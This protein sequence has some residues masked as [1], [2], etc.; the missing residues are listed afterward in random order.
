M[1]WPI[2]TRTV[3]YA[4]AV[5]ALSVSPLSTSLDRSFVPPSVSSPLVVAN[6]SCYRSGFILLKLT[7]SAIQPWLYV[8]L[9]RVQPLHNISL[10]L[11][12]FTSA[13]LSLFLSSTLRLLHSSPIHFLFILDQTMAVWYFLT[14]HNCI[15]LFTC[16]FFTWKIHQHGVSFIDIV[17]IDHWSQ[18]LHWSYKW[19]HMSPFWNI[20]NYM[21][22]I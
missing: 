11:F 10:A 3:R 6:F 20:W 19:C 2:H 5:R 7:T 14:W 18:L 1:Y 15:F 12:S 17:F 9:K 22:L 13:Q 8:V 21:L 4:S 16:L